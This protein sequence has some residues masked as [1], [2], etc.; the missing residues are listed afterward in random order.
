MLCLKLQKVNNT[1][2]LTS[3]S[4]EGGMDSVGVPS[5]NEELISTENPHQKPIVG[6][7]VKVF[8]GQKI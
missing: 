8:G 1:Q 6:S 7:N 4:R 2:L 5:Q 3:H